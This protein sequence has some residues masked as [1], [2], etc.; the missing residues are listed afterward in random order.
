MKSLRFAIMAAALAACAH[1]ETPRQD[2]FVDAAIV[3]RGLRV[4]MRYTTAHNFVGRPID[5]YE[6]PVC[7]LTREAA[8]ALAGYNATPLPKHRPGSSVG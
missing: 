6:A 7:L 4:E 1:A 5:G 2:G 3:V 8:T